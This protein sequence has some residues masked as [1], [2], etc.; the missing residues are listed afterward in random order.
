MELEE[1]YHT[2][3]GYGHQNKIKQGLLYC[4]NPSD[5]MGVEAAVG[6]AENGEVVESHRF[7]L[8][9]DEEEIVLEGEVHSDAEEAKELHDEGTEVTRCLQ[10]FL[11]D[12]ASR[13][14]WL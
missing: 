12:A 4:E 3:K 14:A 13:H 11:D 9:T 5:V 8:D 6:I 2:R 7:F 1:V 10:R